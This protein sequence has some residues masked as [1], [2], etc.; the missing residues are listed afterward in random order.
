MTN[1]EKIKSISIDYANQGFSYLKEEFSNVPNFENLGIFLSKTVIKKELAIICYNYF[2]NL[3]SNSFATIKNQ[4]ELKENIINN[5]TEDSISYLTLGYPDCWGDLTIPIT[6][7][8]AAAGL[9]NVL[10]IILD[11]H[12]ET[13]NT[14]RK[15]NYSR[16]KSKIANFLQNFLS[17]INSGY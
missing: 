12:L 15:Q 5:I 10:T 11:K 1:G 9:K 16:T 6:E 4:H 13:H 3:D 2:I 8:D 7:S 14:T 17:P